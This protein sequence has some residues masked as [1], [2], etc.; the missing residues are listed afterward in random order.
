MPCWPLLLPPPAVRHRHHAHMVS[1]RPSSSSHH[2]AVPRRHVAA[3]VMLSLAIAPCPPS[4]S[5]CH[6]AVHRC[7]SRLCFRSIA[8]AL[9]PSLAVK[10]PLCRPLPS[11]LRSHCAVPCRKGAVVPSIA[12]EEQSRRTSPLRSRRPCR[13]TT[14]ATRHAPPRPL[15]RMVV[16]LPLLTPPP[17][18]CRRLS[19]RHRR[20]CL[21]SVRLV[22]TSPRF[23]RFHLPSVGASAS[24]RAVA[25][26]HAP[27]GPLVQLVKVLPLLTPPPH[28]CGI[29]ESSQ[30][31]GLMLI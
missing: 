18:I 14:P 15:V 13:L 12:I 19:L 4:P 9:T 29:I 5:I 16:A 26:C 7:P 31:S 27:L 28:I 22:V 24:Y 1:H 23:S 8:T 17:S 11:P 2:R 10:E 6:R 25:S 20:L 30:R 3:R 21:P